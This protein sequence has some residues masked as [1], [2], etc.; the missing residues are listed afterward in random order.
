MYVRLSSRQ[1]KILVHGYVRP[2]SRKRELI[3]VMSGLQAEKNAYSYRYSRFVSKQMQLPTVTMYVRFT[4][5]KM[6]ISMAILSV[7]RKKAI[8]HSY[9]RLTRRNM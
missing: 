7:N 8:D 3:T 4:S 6:Q 9:V 5:R 2:V 1:E